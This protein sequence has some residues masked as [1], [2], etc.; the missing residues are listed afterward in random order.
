[1]RENFVRLVLS[2]SCSSFLSVV[3]LR[4]WIIS[5]T[6]S[7][8][9]ATSPIASTVIERVRSPWVTAVATPPIA[10]TRPVRLAALAFTLSVRSFPVPA[11]PPTPARPPRFPPP[12]PP[13]PHPPHSQAP[14]L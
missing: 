11:P 2:Q 4:L 14:P 3:S 7:F 12:P 1:M 8:N 10:R 5:L 9:A 13:P 6:L